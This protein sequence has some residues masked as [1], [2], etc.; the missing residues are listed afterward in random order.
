M[1][2][3]LFKPTLEARHDVAGLRQPWDPRHLMIAT[4][5]CGP[6]TGG[7]LFTANCAR[8]GLPAIRLRIIATAAALLVGALLSTGWMLN[9]TQSHDWRGSVPSEKVAS[10]TVAK[11]S[12]TATLQTPGL[13]EQMGEA[14]AA[15]K[16]ALRKWGRLHRYVWDG[17][18]LL[19][20]Y[21]A[22]RPQWA[23]F[24]LTRHHEVRVGR[25]LWPALGAAVLGLA[26]QCGLYYWIYDYR[27][28]L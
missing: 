27:W 18:T 3:E 16:A 12:L 7:L 11:T 1:N 17:I 2:N 22:A 25:L 26:V 13:L 21:L 4:F 28:I 23:R 19:A 5:L 10:D 24:H 6:L 15:R 9:A 14:A 8:L 20:L